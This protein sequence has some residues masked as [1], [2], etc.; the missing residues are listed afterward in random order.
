MIRNPL[1]RL[2]R[3]LDGHPVPYSLTL[4]RDLPAVVA[5]WVGQAW[6]DRHKPEYEVVLVRGRYVYYYRRAP[7]FWG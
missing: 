1:L 6:L 3:V 5:H 4:D 7:Q 2:V